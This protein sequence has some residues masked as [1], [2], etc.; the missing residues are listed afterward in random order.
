[1]NT[2]IYKYNFDNI[3]YKKTYD[4]L[5]S[6]SDKKAFKDVVG[7]EYETFRKLFYTNLGFKLV[8]SKKVFGTNYN[9]DIALEKD[10]V[11]KIIEESKGHYVDSC[12]LGRAIKDFAKIIKKCLDN[13]IESPFFI[14]SCPTTFNGSGLNNFSDIFNEEIELF[15]DEIKEVLKSKF[16]YQ[17]SCKH[18]RLSKEKYF[19]SEIHSFKLDDEMIEEQI[20]FIKSL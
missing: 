10:G 8:N 9:A 12:F 2:D 19:T 1:M 14:L 17:P 20:L 16:I 11:I 15:R 5:I 6:K 4:R 3:Y 13:K 18:G 7:E